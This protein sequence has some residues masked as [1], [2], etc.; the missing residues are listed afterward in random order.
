MP[1]AVVMS[2]VV[3]AGFAPRT[4]SCDLAV[5][6]SPMGSQDRGCTDSTSKQQLSKEYGLTVARVHQ[7]LK[8][9]GVL[10]RPTERRRAARFPERDEDICREYRDGVSMA[11]IGRNH[12]I[13]GERVRQILKRQGV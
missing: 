4:L 9:G 8:Q 6:R 10:M 12:R 5:A 13:S 1:A 11:D 7:I 2:A 3:E